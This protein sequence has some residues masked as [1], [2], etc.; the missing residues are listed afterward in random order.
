MKATFAA[1]VTLSDFIRAQAGNPEAQFDAIQTQVFNAYVQ[2]L[3]FNNRTQLTAVAD[4]CKQYADVKACKELVNADRIT[5]AVKK[6]HAVYA[7]YAGALAAVGIPSMLAVDSNLKADKLAAADAPAALLAG[8][9]ASLVM[10]ALTPEPKAVKT[11]EEKAKAK[12]DKEKAEKKAAKEA[13]DALAAQVAAEAAKLAET[14][15]VSLSHDDI[16]ALAIDAIKNGMFSKQQ[17]ADIAALAY[18]GQSELL[19]A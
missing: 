13:A 11:E 12:A 5:P 1:A 3:A 4:A 18:A 6:A 15:P 9:F 2:V 10:V 17:L 7:A 8:E 16:F 14:L 19:A